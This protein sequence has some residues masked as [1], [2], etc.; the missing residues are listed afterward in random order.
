MKKQTRHQSLLKQLRNDMQAVVVEPIVPWIVD[1]EEMPVPVERRV[2]PP[3]GWA[4]DEGWREE[5][6]VF[7]SISG[8]EPQA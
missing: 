4:D 3:G 7:Q 8:E 1:P 2:P 6:D 5:A